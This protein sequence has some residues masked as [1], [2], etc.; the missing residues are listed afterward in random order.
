MNSKQRATYEAIF[1]EPIR[2]NI[3][4]KDVVSLIKGLG[5]KVVHGDGSKV[6]LLI[7][8]IS[9]NIHSPHPQ[10][11]MKKYQVKLLREFFAKVN[12]KRGEL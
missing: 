5:G 1:A 10:K 7:D 2:A 8:K 4:W 9:I 12:K 6:Y 11:E 3:L